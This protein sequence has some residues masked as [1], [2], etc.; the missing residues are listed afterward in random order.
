VVVHPE[1]LWQLFRNELEV[2]VRI[3]G[4]DIRGGWF[5]IVVGATPRHGRGHAAR[6]S[7]GA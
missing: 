1:D 4:W 6:R 3:D 5:G 7:H 2:N